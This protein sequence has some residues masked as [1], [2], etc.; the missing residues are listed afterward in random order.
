MSWRGFV[1]ACP[2]C[3]WKAGGEITWTCGCGQPFDAFSSRGRCP[4][5]SS[6]LRRI[7]C[8]RCRT[9]HRWSAWV[10]PRLAWTDVALVVISV[11]L[12]LCVWQARALVYLLDDRARVTAV[13]E[14]WQDADPWGR[15]LAVKVARTWLST[16]VSVH[17]VGPNGIDEGGRGDDVV[18]WGRFS[19]QYQALSLAPSIGLGALAAAALSAI[20]G[21]LP[22]PGRT[23]LAEALVVLGSSAPLATFVVWACRVGDDWLI[24]AST[25]LGVRTG[26]L[27]ATS[28]ALAG[29]LIVVTA[30]RRTHV[31]TRDPAPGTDGERAGARGGA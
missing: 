5:C 24:E 15:P 29:V 22:P 26:W 10:T 30:L 23:E 3:A 8:P 16:D 12:L 4:A 2:L 9:S 11:V 1:A 28:T 7:D 6:A 14:G 17:S 31:A 18:P 21:R 20:V 25:A 27:G 19:W 13:A